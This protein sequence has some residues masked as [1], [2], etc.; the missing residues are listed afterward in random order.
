M[1]S[2]EK[3]TYITNPFKVDEY[4]YSAPIISIEEAFYVFGGFGDGH[5]VQ[6]IGKLDERNNWSQVGD[7]YQQRLSHNVIYDG[8]YALVVGGDDGRFYTEKCQLS[9]EGFYCMRQ[10]P[11][12]SM[13]DY[14]ALFLVSFN[15][16]K[17]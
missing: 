14:P 3:L 10:E 17:N 16:C 13:Y 11:E 15:Y 6:R 7:L 8:N 5:P 9:I 4:I 2:F 1:V 12:L